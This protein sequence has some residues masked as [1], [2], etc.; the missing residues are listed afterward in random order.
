LATPVH[1]GRSADRIRALDVQIAGGVEFL[2][3]EQL[4]AL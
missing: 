2:L 4:R 3:R 1:A